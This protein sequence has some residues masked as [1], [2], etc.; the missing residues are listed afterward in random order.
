MRGRE[1]N[2]NKLSDWNL[3]SG[4]VVLG[5]SHAV[6]LLGPHQFVPRHENLVHFVPLVE[7]AVVLLHL[8][9][10]QFVQSQ[11][12]L[13][14]AK[15]DRLLL[16][17]FCAAKR[18]VAACELRTSQFIVFVL[19]KLGSLH[20]WSHDHE[21]S[22]IGRLRQ[23]VIREARGEHVALALLPINI[24]R[25]TQLLG[26]L[27]AGDLGGRVAHMLQQR[28]ELDVGALASLF[29]H[30]VHRKTFWCCHLQ[31]GAFHTRRGRVTLVFSGLPW[32][33]WV[34]QHHISYDF[35]PLRDFRTRGL[36]NE[37]FR[38]HIV[39]QV[40]VKGL[41]VV[42]LLLLDGLGLPQIVPRQ[43]SAAEPAWMLFHLSVQVLVR[44]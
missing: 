13:V 36:P 37:H 35:N 5:G 29:L 10:I 15:D 43:L 22:G 25:H 18:R 34:V 6:L 40:D 38:V 24:L 19:N 12:A 16:F 33:G 39:L 2:V 23:F 44:A 27:R 30:H 42:Q 3:P 20:H 26:V 31:G 21:T 32:R 41:R 1:L 4:L 9:Q 8:A 14:L 17:L 28:L 11:H 7:A